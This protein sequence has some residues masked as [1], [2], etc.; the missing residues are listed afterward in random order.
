MQ[1]SCIQ[2]KTLI[3]QFFLNNMNPYL[4]II[5]PAYN[6]A[7]R[8]NKTLLSIEE[9]L[10]GKLFSYEIIVVDDG[11]I[12]KTYDLLKDT[13]K[14][15][16]SLRII[17]LPENKGKG[18]AVKE[19]MTNSLGEIRLFMD[20][21]GST[22]I[23]EIE[24]LIPFIGKGNDVVI[25][26]RIIEGSVKKIKQNYIREFLGWLYR[27][28]VHF[29]FDLT[30]KDT[31][32]GFKLFTAKSAQKIFSSLEIKG[33]GFDMEILLIAKK[34]N[35]SIKE[36]PIVWVNDPRSKLNFLHMIKMLE[37]LLFVYRKYNF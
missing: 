32:N 6:E 34:M 11:S 27:I 12:D 2:A 35:Y 4:S 8:I 3:F 33:W 17:K 15:I 14:T 37:D 25:G 28:L 1:Y 16:T 13:K 30:I 24:K 26:S 36:V 20:A 7:D 21:D 5:I 29:I 10:K 31:Q 19:G 23:E 22:S 9:Y 18:F